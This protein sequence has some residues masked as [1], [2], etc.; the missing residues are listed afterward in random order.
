MTIKNVALILA[1]AL[2]LLAASACS[3]PE[4]AEAQTP[5]RSSQTTHAKT[6]FPVKRCLN[7]GNALEAPQEGDWGYRIAARDFQTIAQAGFDTVRIP[8]RWDSH[9]AHSRPYP[10]DA[11]FMARIKQVVDQAQTQGL[12]VIIDVHH[13]ENLMKYTARETPRFL[14]IWDQISRAFS[15]APDSVYFEPLNEPTR[16]ISTAKLNALYTQVL[17]IIRAS[18]PKRFVILG[19]NSWNSVERLDAVTWPDD[20]YLIATFHDYGPHEFTHQGATWMDPVL[21][22]GRKWG[23]KSDQRE[24]RET[25]D[26]A[27]AFQGKTDLPIFVGEFGVIDTVPQA[28]RN[29]WLRARRLTLEA[30]GYGWCVWDF[31]GAFKIYNSQ[32]RQWD[33]GVLEALFS[34]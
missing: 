25:Y 11:Q 24:L 4:Q 7:M 26:I 12:Q 22:T 17:P 15:S 2:G 30:H 13:Y 33:A 31:S 14:A 6:N 23:R 16:Q 9:T 27:R 18:N 20:P 1:M 3:E 34:P 8:V 32:T 21:K 5:N 29:Q 19:G 28:E 10:I